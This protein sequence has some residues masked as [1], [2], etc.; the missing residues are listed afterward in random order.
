M[1]WRWRKW[2]VGGA[3]EVVVDECWPRVI[4]SLVAYSYRDGDVFF[5]FKDKK[6]GALCIQQCNLW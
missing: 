4:Y 3:R 5:I 1:Q 6:K 2:P